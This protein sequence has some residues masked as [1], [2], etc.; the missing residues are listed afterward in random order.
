MATQTAAIEFY[1]YTMP[2]E[3]ELFKIASPTEGNPELYGLRLIPVNDSLPELFVWCIY[4]E[5]DK[6]FIHSLSDVWS[7]YKVA[8]YREYGDKD[9]LHKLD[10]WN[11]LAALLLAYELN[12]RLS[13]VM[14]KR[15]ELQQ[16]NKLSSMIG[17]GTGCK[18][19]A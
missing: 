3:G 8:E 7:G 6:C 2:V 10:D 4:S 9:D 16:I 11:W 13:K 15:N 12:G 1:Q 18:Q 17:G 14:V 19:D 5:S